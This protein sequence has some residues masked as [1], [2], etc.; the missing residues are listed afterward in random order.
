M[1]MWTSGKKRGFTL[2]ELL[3][4]MALFGALATISTSGYYAV[5]R[6]MEERGAISAA[7]GIARAAQ[8]RARIDRVPTALYLYNELVKA[9]SGDDDAKVQGVAIAVRMGGRISMVARSGSCLCDEFTDLK[10]IYGLIDEDNP[11]SSDKASSS[12][13]MRLYQMPQRIDGTIQELD[14]SVVASS[15]VLYEHDG[16]KNVSLSGNALDERGK[17]G[18]PMYAFVK[19]S[20][21]NGKADWKNGDA[22]AFEFAS[23]RLPV[24]YYFGYGSKPD[25]PKNADT[26]VKPVKVVLFSPYSSENELD[27]AASSIEIYTDRPNKSGAPEPKSIGKVQRKATDV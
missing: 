21:D 3:V 5:V 23:V 25:T 6:G 24:G 14:Y 19:S 12:D 27:S 13:G 22:Y 7:S 16:E 10:D 15:V 8:Q 26:P 9:E 17:N 11:T 1:T 2:V 20:S 4:V 18:I